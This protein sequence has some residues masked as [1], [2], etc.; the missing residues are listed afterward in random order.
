MPGHLPTRVSQVTKVPLVWIGPLLLLSLAGAAAGQTASAQGSTAKKSAP[1]GPSAVATPA[2]APSTSATPKTSAKPA[3]AASKPAAAKTAPATRG[4]VR[5]S[6]AASRA[7]AAAAAR[8]LAVPHYRLDEDGDLVPDLRAAA[9]IIYDPETNEVLWEENSQTQRSIASLT[10]MMTAAVFLETDPDLTESVVIA[11]SD[12]YRASTTMLRYNDR[13]T[14]DDLL[15]LL[16][17]A[18][19]NAAARALA[20]VSVYGAQAF[21]TRMNQKAIELG[22]EQTSY[23][24]PS[25]LKSGNRSSAY[26]MARL[27][28][29]ASS[30]ERIGTIMRTPSYQFRTARGRPVS[31]RNT[32]QLLTRPDLD[33]RAGKTGYISSSGY[34]LATLLRLPQGGQEVAVVVLGAQSNAARF[35]EARNL[36][37]WM[38]TRVSALLAVEPPPAPPSFLQPSLFQ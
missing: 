7:R 13:V 30:D 12:V 15:H 22:L 35:A 33:V 31:V 1:A 24:E 34:C 25:G 17:I 11:R 37:E 20:R 19:D 4:P 5:R 36:F 21:V 2:P 6:T 29:I 18:S 14:A 16:L 27:I 3:T 38:S 10:K 8:A 28:A 23:A 9:A 32:N 26:D